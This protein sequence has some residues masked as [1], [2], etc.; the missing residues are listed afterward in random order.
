MFSLSLEG[1]E[2]KENEE[3]AKEFKPVS[4]PEYDHHFYIN[5]K[6]YEENTHL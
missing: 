5:F 4:C 2:V 1:C 6:N 3:A